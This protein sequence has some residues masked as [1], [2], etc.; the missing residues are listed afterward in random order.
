[1]KKRLSVLL[2]SAFTAILALVMAVPA[3]AATGDNTITINSETSGHTFEAYQV[4]AGEY[5]EVDEVATLS[6]VKW[7][8]GVD[9]EKIVDGKT[10]LQA[11]QADATIGSYFMDDKTAAD[12]ADT[13][14]TAKVGD[15]QTKAFEDNAANIDAFANVVSGY[16][17]STHTD[18][19]DP[20]GTDPYVYTISNVGDGYYFIKDKNNSLPAGQANAYTKFMLQV[21]ADVIVNAKADVPTIDKTTGEPNQ[22]TTIDLTGNNASIGDAV[23]F[24]ITSKVPNMD[25]YNNYF[26]IV[27]DTLSEGLSFNADSLVVKVGEKTLARDASADG[28]GVGDYY[29]KDSTTDAGETELQIVFKNF[30]NY[31]AGQNVEITYTATVTKDAVIGINGNLNEAYLEYSNNPNVDSDGD[32]PDDDDVTGETPKVTTKT[33]VTGIE[34]HKVDETGKSLEG[35]QFTISGEKINQVL[36]TGNVFTQSE[37]G[38]YYKL[39][40]GSYTTTEPN[41]QTEDEYESTTIKYVMEEKTELVTSTEHVVSTAQVGSDGKLVFDGLAAGDYVITEVKSPDGYNLL[42]EP[43]EVT[44]ECTISEPV[45][46]DSTCTWTAKDTTTNDGITVENGVV[47]ITVQNERGS[48]LPS[49]GGMGTTMFYVVG[50]VLVAGAAVAYV[51]KR[52]MDANNA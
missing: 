17:S 20:T 29:V 49:T 11:L 51:V 6:N 37:N 9:A 26:F 31:T 48:L 40:D 16:L 19:G 30:V 13:L 39:K 23:P 41:A 35:A 28:S 38:T 2:A 10:L 44:I 52:R 46:E 36:M 1:M 14:A 43:I 32:Y 47:K 21:V 5:A 15:S 22:T 8:D 3:Y 24:K 50:G 12:V 45:S 27:H 25:G 7:G 33:F 34:L 4:F 42:E 18:S